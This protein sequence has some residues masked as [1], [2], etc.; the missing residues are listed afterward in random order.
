[1]TQPIHKPDWFESASGLRVYPTIPDAA[2]VEVGDIARALSHCCR[3]AGH[4][5][6]FYS[7]ATHSMLVQELVSSQ[8][9]CIHTQ[10]AALIHDA[11]EAYLHDI[12][13]PLKLQM[14]WYKDL[15]TRWEREILHKL[16]I[17]ASR[18]DWDLV[19]DAD[20]EALRL[21]A[22]YLMPSR[23]AEWNIPVVRTFRNMGWFFDP[24]GPIDMTM[25]EASDEFLALWTESFAPAI[26]VLS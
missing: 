20:N 14:P 2:V 15:E 8:T 1:M 11:A 9:E 13:R 12:T 10:A 22:A 21:E 24:Q 3:F 5:R 7:V 19:K 4:C 26:K 18:V 17:D 16:G 6:E 23:G 25:N